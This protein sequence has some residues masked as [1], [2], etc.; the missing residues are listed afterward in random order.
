MTDIILK[1]GTPSVQVIEYT[2]TE[3][4]QEFT[5]VGN[6]GKVEIN[7][8]TDNDTIVKKPKGVSGSACFMDK[9]VGNSLKR[10][11]IMDD[12]III[13]GNKVTIGVSSYVNKSGDSYLMEVVLE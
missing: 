5:F 4:V 12:G 2:G 1:S 11:K 6:V 8:L 7:N 3:V 9:T 10:A 13:L